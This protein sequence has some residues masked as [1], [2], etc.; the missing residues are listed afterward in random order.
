MSV[1]TKS[2]TAVLP[3]TENLSQIIAYPSPYQACWRTIQAANC[4]HGSRLVVLAIAKVRRKSG[5]VIPQRI[6][7]FAY[8]PDAH[9]S[10]AFL[11]VD[12]YRNEVC[13][14]TWTILPADAS[15]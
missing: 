12:E 13:L 8:S 11:I 5:L 1:P 9:S 10:S 15:G 2:T 6:L 3:S 7:P 14:I 4:C